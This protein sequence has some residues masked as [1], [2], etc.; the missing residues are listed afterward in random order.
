MD[1]HADKDSKIAP[2]V[3]QSPGKGQLLPASLAGAPRLGS[4]TPLPRVY[5]VFDMVF[6]Y[7]FPGQESRLLFRCECFSCSEK[8]LEPGEKGLTG[9]GRKVSFLTP[10]LFDF[11]RIE[12][13]DGWCY[14]SR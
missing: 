5:A 12:G 3:S 4:G 10:R 11:M 9:I 6:L 8:V 13:L 7:W 1:Q 2:P 14:K